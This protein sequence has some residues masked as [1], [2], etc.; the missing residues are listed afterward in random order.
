LEALSNYVDLRQY[1]GDYA[2]AVSFAE[3]AYNLVVDIYD[4]VHPPSSIGSC[5][6]SDR[7]PDQEGRFI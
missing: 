1:Q 2:G 3:E 5:W 7:L 6:L 4:P